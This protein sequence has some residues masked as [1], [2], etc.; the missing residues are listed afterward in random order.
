MSTKKKTGSETAQTWKSTSENGEFRSCPPSEAGATS[1]GG[2][3]PLPE[4]Y[5]TII[6]LLKFE[7]VP[8]LP[9]TGFIAETSD[10]HEPYFHAYAGRGY[11]VSLIAKWDYLAEVLP[12]Y[13]LASGHRKGELHD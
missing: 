13:C 6:V 9:L 11:D 3:L 5:V 2:T 10:T 4:K 1:R 12:G 7:D 8:P